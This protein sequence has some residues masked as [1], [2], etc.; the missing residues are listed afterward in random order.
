MSEAE[1]GK[2]GKCASDIST[3]AERCPECGYEPKNEN[4]TGRSIL[5]VIGLLLTGTI[6][7]S[8]VGIPLMYITYKAGKHAKTLKPTNTDPDDTVSVSELLDA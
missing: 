3:E 1:T 5:M 6:I 7:G 2:C 4:S 8:V